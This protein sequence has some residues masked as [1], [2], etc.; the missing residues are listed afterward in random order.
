MISEFSAMRASAVLCLAIAICSHAAG[1]AAPNRPQRR[2]R[3]DPNIFPPSILSSSFNGPIRNPDLSLKGHTSGVRCL[4]F[5]PDGKILASASNDGTVRLW[6]VATAK[7][8]RKVE[9]HVKPVTCVSFSADGKRII[10]GGDDTTARI[11]DVTTGDQL[12][13]FETRHDHFALAAFLPDGKHVVLAMNETYP[14]LWD[15]ETEKKVL[16]FGPKG[17]RVH[18]AALSRDGAIVVSDGCFGGISA[19]NTKTAEV[20]FEAKHTEPSDI[21]T[22]AFTPDGSKVFVS[23]MFLPLRAWDLKSSK[24]VIER[25]KTGEDRNK[26]VS[27]HKIAISPDGKLLAMLSHINEGHLYDPATGKHLE[28]IFL[29]NDMAHAVAFSPDSRYLAT[30]G[31]GLVDGPNFRPSYDNIIR[32]WDL[33]KILPTTRPA[34]P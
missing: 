27:G 3:P 14:Q 12:Y 17:H 33:S 10:S 30:A 7:E 22:V 6:D 32:L 21:S 25:S 2:A 5:S 26:P 18:S 15:I 9:G 23:S 29:G 19:F 13:Q 24:L 34:N 4:C 1:A 8:I 11:W 28:S 20:C 16:E 31:G